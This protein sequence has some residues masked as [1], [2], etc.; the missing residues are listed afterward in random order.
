MNKILKNYSK[1]RINETKQGF[2]EN[3]NKTHKFVTRERERATQREREKTPMN[4]IG[5]QRQTLQQIPI[6]F[7]KS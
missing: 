4:K 1:Q 5:H 2:F 3:V 6:K 7:R